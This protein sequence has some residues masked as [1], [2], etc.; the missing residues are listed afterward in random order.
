MP[1][2]SPDGARLAFVSRSASD[3]A[4]WTMDQDGGNKRRLVTGDAPD[5][6]PNGQIAYA[7]AWS[8]S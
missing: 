3:I 7:T 2:W 5:W 1:S 8:G 4:V 6:G